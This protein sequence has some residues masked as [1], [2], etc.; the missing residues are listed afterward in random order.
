MYEGH[1]QAVAVFLRESGRVSAATLS[2]LGETI[3]AT[4]EPLAEAVVRRGLVE[5][6]EFLR[7]VATH[8]GM[9]CLEELPQA[10]SPAVAAMVP[11]DLAR[12]FR[13]I[14]WRE[15]PAALELAAVDPFAAGLAGE[16]SF[17]LGREVQIV[18]ADPARIAELLRIH[19]AGPARPRTEKCGNAAARSGTA[20]ASINPRRATLSVRRQR[21]RW[22][23]LVDSVLRQAIRDHASDIHFEPFEGEFRVRCRVDGTLREV[24]AP[25]PAQ[26]PRW[27][28][29]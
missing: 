29:D 22:C 17:A 27:C 24:A 8:L 10:L 9:P 13:V 11:G 26:A 7:G 15:G 18:V 4:C 25:P 19:Y 20:R 12:R 5:R 2:R 16:L 23:S 1:D 14:P 28:R 3:A 21:R 6:A